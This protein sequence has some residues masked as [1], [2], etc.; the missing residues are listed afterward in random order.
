MH[1]NIINHDLTCEEVIEIRM[2]LYENIR[3]IEKLLEKSFEYNIKE[4]ISYY[5][6]RLSLMKSLQDKMNST[7]GVKKE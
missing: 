7:F 2:S 3:Q 4:N 5:S 6:E 1:K